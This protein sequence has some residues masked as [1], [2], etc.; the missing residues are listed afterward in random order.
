MLYDICENE[1]QELFY[2][3]INP[4]A[5]IP[6]HIP[7]PLGYLQYFIFVRV[8][9]QY[10]DVLD[11]VI[12]QCDV[13][14]L[15]ETH[16]AVMTGAGVPTPALFPSQQEGMVWRC[17]AGTQFARGEGTLQ[18]LHWPAELASADM[19]ICTW[20]RFV[21]SGQA[22]AW[23]ACQHDT[24]WAPSGVPLGGIGGGRVDICRDGRFRNFSMNNNQDT[25]LE[26]PDG[27][28]GAYLAM[29]YAGTTR[30]LT[31]R[32]V[33]EGQQSAATFHYTARFPQA[34]LASE[35][36]F[37]GIDT[38]V[39]FSGPLCP[40][41]LRR[42]SIPGFLIRWEVCNLNTDDR[43]VQCTM[44]WPNLIGVGGAIARVESGIGYG[45]GF[46]RHWDQ[47][48]GRRQ[49]VIAEAGF[50]AIRYYGE[51]PPEMLSTAGDH[52]LA[53][54][55]DVGVI[56]SINPEKCCASATVTVPAGESVTI[57]M[58]LVTAMPHFVDSFGIDRGAY[59]QRNFV[60]GTT[61][62]S[63]FLKEADAILGEASSLAALLDDSTLPDWLKTRL[64]NCTYPLV[65][66]SV[67]YQDGR[68]SVNEGPTEMAGCYGTIDQ[69]LA[70]HPATQL[71]F[72]ELNQAEL[73]QFANIQGENGGIQHDLG[74]GHLER[75]PG[76]I[77]WPDLT[78]SFII[79]VA[80]H[81]WSTGDETFSEQ[82]W[83]RVRRALLRHAQWAEEGKGVA[84]VGEG[85]GTSYD[86]YHYIG[87][88]GY[89][90]TLW[91]AALAVVEQW[92]SA[93]EDAELLAQIAQ[94]RTAAI[95]RLEADL[96]TGAYYKAY[97]KSDGSGRDSCHAGQLAGQVFTRLLCNHNVLEAGRIA[98]CLETMLTLQG[99]PLF[100][101]PPDEVTPEGKSAAGYCWLPYVE[102]FMLTAVAAQHD[103]RLWPLWERMIA[104]VDGNSAHPCDTRLMY[105]PLQGELAWGSYYMT[106]PASWLVYDAW[107][108]FFYTPATGVLRLNPSL[109]GR[110]P[111][112]HPR[113]WGS[114][115]MADGKATLTIQRVFGDEPC[116]LRAIQ[117]PLKQEVMP[118]VGEPVLLKAGTV[119]RWKI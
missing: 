55:T 81:A 84:Q 114:V 18:F 119:V 71:L 59:W 108:D 1:H 61:M 103:P 29:S 42:S 58:A 24:Q 16:E 12:M 86:G 54:R 85:L 36:I 97:G 98:Q 3:G 6:I 30:E 100:A 35:G 101:L 88:T 23:L 4:A 105:R 99:N 19:L 93:K 92:A 63:T 56:P 33:V 22:D 8:P 39:L 43:T 7:S 34:T 53:I 95:T 83:P 107:L 87:T 17:L 118:L 65:T 104:L 26:D 5:P 72:P 50:Q 69:R 15:R 106:A 66:N 20:P 45:D 32:P 74:G 44:G 77:P 21:A 96:W 76:E 11:E 47:A 57:T 40:H 46:Y 41:D 116:Y 94:W 82:M 28:A 48:S 37:P 14:G 89:M 73:Q 51:V 13:V 78:C 111:L 60:D 113:F 10:A 62:L 117:I 80:R 102:G 25:P 79:Q 70:A 49:E 52:Y 2:A 38:K 112:L 9:E 90:A 68:F 64:S 110:Y 109:T 75:K 31:S 67:F 27:L 115:E 91:L